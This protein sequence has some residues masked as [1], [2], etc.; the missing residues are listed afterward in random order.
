MNKEMTGIW[1]KM[2]K[3][4]DAEKYD[5]AYRLASRLVKLSHG[6]DT[7]PPREKAI[8]Q[9]RAGLCLLSQSDLDKADK[10]FK[11]ALAIVDADKELSQSLDKGIF[12]LNLA[13]SRH[14]AGAAAE[15]DSLYRQSARIHSAL[16]EPAAPEITGLLVSCGDEAAHDESIKNYVETM[17]MRAIDLAEFMYG[18]GY[19]GCIALQKLADRY[20]AA[21]RVVELKMILLNLAEKYGRIFGCN[22]QVYGDICSRLARLFPDDA[23]MA[24]GCHNIVLTIQER[25]LEPDFV[26]LHSSLDDLAA[27]H[28]KAGETKDAEALLAD[29]LVR[30]ERHVPESSALPDVLSRLA[31]IHANQGDFKRAEAEQEKAVTIS[32][33]TEK[34]PG[35]L[36]I[37]VFQLGVIQGLEG[38][39]KDDLRGL[40]KAASTYE[41]AL[42][43]AERHFGRTHLN[44]AVVLENL[45]GIRT[46]LKSPAKAITL[47][48]RALSIKRKRLGA[49]DSGVADTLNDLAL[50]YLGQKDY[51]LACKELRHALSILEAVSGKGS[52]K[53]ATVMNNLAVALTGAGKKME[54]L[55]M[56]GR[57]LCMREDLDGADS[58]S[59]ITSLQNLAG[60]KALSGD[61]VEAK[62]VFDR[63]IHLAEIHYEPDSEFMKRLKDEQTALAA[64]KFRKPLSA[65]WVQES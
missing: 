43:M 16:L 45:A 17:A 27:L 13:C 34:T 32:P 42:T 7:V 4:M 20:Q 11:Q 24:K 49:R 47:Y 25:L 57:E 22:S 29:L 53:R 31:T 65:F 44:V 46:H 50:V 51:L 21:D 8:I 6:N 3:L 28:E 35:N 14:S 36:A 10:H 2:S 62:K 1:S 33:S 40:K 5:E 55:E 9:N 64:G 48:R 19:P 61:S 52:A 63:A 23:E 30:L 38:T 59:L 39:E 12:L 56:A 58:A 54:G 26:Q 60:L 18:T 37:R 15:G 41:R